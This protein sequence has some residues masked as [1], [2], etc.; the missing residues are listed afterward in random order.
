MK[1]QVEEGTLWKRILN[2]EIPPDKVSTEM[3]A[4]VKEYRKRLA[5][6]GFRKGYAPLGLVQAQ[7]GSGLDAE[8]LQRVVP[9]A[10]EEALREVNL[11]PV[12]DPTFE[13]IKLS[14]ERPSASRRLSR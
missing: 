8:F 14:V 7:L 4:V 11:A 5:I 9:R 1:V 6:P 13:D 2:I 12:S 3:E 10:Y